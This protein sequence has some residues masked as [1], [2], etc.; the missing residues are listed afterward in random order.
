MLSRVILI[1]TAIAAASSFALQAKAGA[2]DNTFEPIGPK[3]Q[4]GDTSLAVRLV[5][6]STGKPVTDAVIV[7]S[8][9]DMG[10]DGM[11]TM[12]SQ[13][14]PEPSSEPGD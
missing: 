9:I 2:E 13:I 7:R 5:Q 12:E 6:K 4:K 8:R 1:A 14:A 11:P 10:P 3:L